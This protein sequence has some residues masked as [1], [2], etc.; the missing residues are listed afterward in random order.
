MVGKADEDDED[1]E[2]VEDKDQEYDP[3]RNL[4]ELELLTLLDIDGTV[5]LDES[6]EVVTW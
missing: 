6:Y 2:V 3:V 5:E 4:L 1:E